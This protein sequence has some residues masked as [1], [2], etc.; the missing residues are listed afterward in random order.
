MLCLN[1]GFCREAVQPNM[2]TA[3]RLNPCHSFLEIIYMNWDQIKGDWKQVQGKVKSQWG[4]LTDDDLKVI[5]GKREELAGK[6]QHHYGLGKE[7][8]EEELDSFI[9][10]L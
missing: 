8:A 10:G 3:Q 6:L 9:K 2:V 5:D 1:I 7:K 4:K